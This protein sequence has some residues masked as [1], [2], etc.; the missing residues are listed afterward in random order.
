MPPKLPSR[1]LLPEGLGD[2][3]ESASGTNAQD[4]PRATYRSP[5]LHISVKPDDHHKS[6]IG[7]DGSTCSTGD[8]MTLMGTAQLAPSCAALMHSTAGL[9]PS[10]TLL[11]PG[12]TAIRPGIMLWP[13]EGVSRVLHP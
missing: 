11:K 7:A 9:N 6:E 10:A 5:T 4:G 1:R 8:G 13:L 12:T 2:I 3:P